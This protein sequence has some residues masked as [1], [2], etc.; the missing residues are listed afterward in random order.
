MRR[1]LEAGRRGFSLIVVDLPRLLDALVQETLSRCDQLIVL[2]P[3]TFSALASGT[4]LCQS[5]PDST[6]PRKLIA[7]GAGLVVTNKAADTM[8]LPLLAAMN[9]QRGLDE[10]I[11]LGAG[12]LRRRKGPL[13]RAAVAAANEMSRIK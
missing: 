5:L 7:R 12:P 8:R 1:V 11:Y 3:M 9:D 6:L 10:D 2:T 4:R 13:G